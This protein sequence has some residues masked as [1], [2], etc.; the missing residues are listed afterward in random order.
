MADPKFDV[1]LNPT[2]Q[3]K[4]KKIVEKLTVKFKKVLLF[5]FITHSLLTRYSRA[6]TW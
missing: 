2:K 1:F 3:E 5:Y 4:Q 6:W